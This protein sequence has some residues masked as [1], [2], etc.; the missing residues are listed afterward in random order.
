MRRFIAMLGSIQ[1]A[2]ASMKSVVK[3]LPM[4]IQVPFCPGAPP[5]GAHS[6][7]LRGTVDKPIAKVLELL[8][9]HKTTSSPSIDEMEVRKLENTPTREHH[10]VSFVIRPFP[11][12]SI[13]WTEEWVYRVVAGSRE[14]PREVEIS[15]AKT[16]GTSHIEHLCGSIVLRKLGPASTEVFQYEEAKATRRSRDDTARGLAGTLEALGKR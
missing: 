4:Q 14:R 3:P 16:D 6:A 12:I 1:A 10:S 2:T 7:T 9:D 15:K 8:L 11:L 13:R 5:P